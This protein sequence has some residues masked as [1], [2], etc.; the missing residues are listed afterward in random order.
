M[1]SDARSPLQT[2]P[3][4]SPGVTT[5][6]KPSHRESVSPVRDLSRQG[7]PPTGSL[8]ASP[9]GP[10]SQRPHPPGAGSPEEV[11]PARS[12]L[13]PALPGPGL[14]TDRGTS[15]SHDPPCG[16]DPCRN[17]PPAP[18]SP[19][20]SDLLM[21]RSRAH[22]RSWGSREALPGL[23]D[24]E[25]S[26]A[27]GGTRQPPSP[28]LAVAA[29]P[30]AAERCPSPGCSQH[31]CARAP[32]T[33]GDSAFAFLTCPALPAW[34]LAHSTLDFSVFWELSQAGD[35]GARNTEGG[36]GRPGHPSHRKLGDRGRSVAFN[37]LFQRSN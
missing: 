15:V 5:L 18:P 36:R 26:W 32:S 31:R 25:N 13:L 37:E 1:E 35:T 19:F 11:A 22:Q 21:G 20:R 34:A 27:A 2:R 29:R 10:S 24:P 30:L 23:L 7:A 16:Q 6:P 9:R 14:P 8:F 3:L 4:S 28:C 17:T 12:W 33:A